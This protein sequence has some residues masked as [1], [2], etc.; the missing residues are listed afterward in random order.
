M[1]DRPTICCAG[2]VMLE[3]APTGEPDCYRRGIAGDTFNTAVYLSRLGCQVSYLTRLGAD[4]ASTHI[5]AALRDEGIDDSLI[6]AVPGRQPGLYLIDNDPTGERRFSYW[7]DHSPARE[8]FDTPPSVP[9]GD[10][11]YFSGITLAV[12]RSGLHNLVEV[13]RGLREAG[14]RI[15]FDPNYRPALWREPQQAR[16]CYEAVLP[17]CD[18]VLPTLDDES[19]LWGIN[20]VGQCASFHRQ[21]GVRELVIKAPDLSAHGF[22]DEQAA[23]CAAQPVS[24]VDTTGAGDAFNAGYLAGR[25]RGQVIDAAIRA[26]QALAAAVVQHRGAIIARQAFEFEEYN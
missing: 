14:T 20:D 18:I 17:L 15:A 19:Q 25:L 8:T 9:A 13:L 3:F 21:F 6:L 12:C 22:C 1:P 24:A 11:F 16:S 7:R 26:G 10:A 5:L 23:V 4:P 2:E